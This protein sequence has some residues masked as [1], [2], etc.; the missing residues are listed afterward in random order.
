MVKMSCDDAQLDWC[1]DL[2]EYAKRLGIKPRRA[3]SDAPLRSPVNTPKVPA[4]SARHQG[5]F[6]VFEEANYADSSNPANPLRIIKPYK[7]P[8]IDLYAEREA[9]LKGE[10]TEKEI[11][12]A[13]PPKPYEPL[14]D[15]RFWDQQN[16]IHDAELK[17]K[18]VI[19]W[20]PCARMAGPPDTIDLYKENKQ[21]RA[22]AAINQKA[23]EAEADA[24]RL[25][26]EWAEKRKAQNK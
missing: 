9:R 12:E 23:E 6:K 5:Q 16:R 1:M 25:L 18:K 15:W 14:A 19:Q 24:Q 4:G 2:T 11:E 3:E 22:Q 8:M 13:R 21:R 20:H 10:V 26:M 7:K 17:G